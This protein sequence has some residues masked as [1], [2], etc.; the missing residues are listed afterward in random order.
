MSAWVHFST[1]NG[2]LPP[3]SL[4]DDVITQRG[5]KRS[6]LERW[7]RFL[8]FL[9]LTM[10]P[11]LSAINICFPLMAD[12]GNRRW[13]SASNCAVQPEGKAIRMK[14]MMREK[15]PSGRSGSPSWYIFIFFFFPFLFLGVVSFTSPWQPERPV[16]TG[17]AGL[18]R[19]QIRGRW[20]RRVV[21]A[22]EERRLE[23]KISLGHP[24]KPFSLW[25]PLSQ[26]VPGRSLEAI[27]I[28]GWL[29]PTTPPTD[30]SIRPTKSQRA[31]AAT[32]AAA[33]ETILN[34]H[35][36]SHFSHATFTQHER[37]TTQ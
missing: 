2:P 18:M 14:R 13:A 35:S 6:W 21:G 32:A 37:Q 1:R 26:R 9:H 17:R 22:A 10:A 4:C 16:I 5:F 11:G 36:Q 29:R 31:A 28:R 19:R 34:G 33:Q 25:L 7:K 8:A 20:R 12:L 30:R 23:S 3:L 15:R 27:V 24:S